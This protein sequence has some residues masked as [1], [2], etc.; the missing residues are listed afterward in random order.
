MSILRLLFGC[1]HEP[2]LTQ[3]RQADGSL[4]IPHT[5]EWR[6]VKCPAVLGVTSLESKPLKLTRAGRRVLGFVQRRSA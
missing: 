3:K 4:V 1:Q 6:C 5:I 2:L